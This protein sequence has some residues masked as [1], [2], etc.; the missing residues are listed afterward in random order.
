M[1]MSEEDFVPLLLIACLCIVIVL[2]LFQF[3]KPN[4]EDNDDGFFL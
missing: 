4:K 1:K 2:V 3:D